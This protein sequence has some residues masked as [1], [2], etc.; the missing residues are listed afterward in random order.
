MSE[1]EVRKTI[2]ELLTLYDLEPSIRDVFVEGPSDRAVIEWFLAEVQIEDVAVQE[3]ATVDIPYEETQKHSLEDNNRGRVIALAFALQMRAGA[4][5]TSSV[6]CIADTDLDTVLERTYDC[7]LLIF[8]VFTSLELY[9]YDPIIVGKF[10]RLVITNFR[11]DTE[12]ILS[13]F[14]GV[15]TELFLI[16]VANQE[17]RFGIKPLPF[18]KF[19]KINGY[20]IDFDQTEYLTRYLSKGAR[21]RAYDR[22]V[23]LVQEYSN[24]LPDD[25]RTHMHGHDFVD[26][27]LLYVTEM[28]KPKKAYQRELFARS[29]FG[30]LEPRFIQNKPLFQELVNRFAST[31]A[32]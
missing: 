29:L 28:K 27:L 20:S 11:R 1:A 30:V 3:I 25:P 26:L 22:F 24:R 6:A 8:T 7:P 19:L 5:L 10:F 18:N 2:D 17:L 4:D 15:L 23:R 16:R 32:D 31:G 9:L 12:K 21:L 13:A 14:T